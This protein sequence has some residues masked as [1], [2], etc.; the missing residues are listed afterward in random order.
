MTVLTKPQPEKPLILDKSYGRTRSPKLP[1]ILGLHI[2]HD[3]TAV[4]I[5]EGKL[6]AAIGE[7]RLSR[8][9]QHY[10]FPQRA[11]A[12]VL[13]QAG[14]E[15]VDVDCIA[16]GGGDP[17]RLNPWQAAHIYNLE[18]NGDIDFSNTVPRR[19]GQQACLGALGIGARK[20]FGA[21]DKREAT[22][23]RCLHRCLRTCNLD[24]RKLQVV[25]HHL[26]HAVSAFS[27]SDFTT[28]LGVTI[29][30]YGD[31]INTALWACSPTTIEAIARGP[32]TDDAA[33]YSPGDF[34]S[35]VTRYLGYKR[36]RHE[37]KITGLAAYASPD[38]LLATIED[39]LTLDQENACFASSVSAFRNIRE[40]RPGVILR[41]LLRWALSGQL[42][43]PML[44]DE[45]GAR[46]RGFTPAQVAAAAQALLEIRVLELIGYWTQNTGYKKVC[47]SG[48][49]FAN[50]K[51]NQ[52][53]SELPGV[54]DV[55]VHPNMGDGGLATGAA[56][57]AAGKSDQGEILRH[58]LD[59][60]FL[61]P[62][63]NLEQMRSALE[64]GGLAYSRKDCIERSIAETVHSGRVVARFDGRMEYGPR[65]LGNRSILAAPT[66]P[67]INDWLNERLKRTE[68]MPFAPAVLTEAAEEIFSSIPVGRALK[69]MTITLDVE[70][71][72]RMKAPAVCHVDGTARPQFL[73]RSS[74]PSFYKVV[75]EYQRLSGIPLVINTSFNIHEEP[76]VCTPEDAVRAF[77]LGHLDA[78]ALGPFWVESPRPRGK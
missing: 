6:V 28:A 13:S 55:C 36:N 37:G 59:D 2:G 66:D 72:W 56:F 16:I 69:F 45:L 71:E 47:L 54:E 62:A 12:Q 73:D 5:V 52:R 40:R 77:R 8:I 29:D 63:F 58:C 51:L 57:W 19:I 10:G 50:V 61:G 42:W 35:Y 17:L 3:A 20:I 15:A 30:G 7:E 64:A 68:F 74:T 76:I 25:D 65:A 4:L 46:C 11:I 22:A 1:V 24:P 60:V 70:P 53:I 14:I 31:G 18:N 9:K 49:V 43:D 34:Y 38:D 44:V 32:S 23:T 33:A 67:D 75:S 39:L 41:R 26:C 27:T 48:G 21:T 78:L